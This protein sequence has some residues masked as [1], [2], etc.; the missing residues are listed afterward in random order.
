MKKVIFVVYYIKIYIF[1]VIVMKDDTK[2]LL[3]LLRYY[4]KYMLLCII[5]IVLSLSYAGISLLSPIF[6]GK[7]LSYYENFNKNKII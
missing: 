2:N 4:K 6:E 1:W 3:R 5:V 7:L